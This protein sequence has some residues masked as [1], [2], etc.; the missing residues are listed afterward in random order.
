MISILIPAHK[1]KEILKFIDQI[2]YDIHQTKQIIVFNDR[3]G[4]GKGYALRE[5]LKE[6][7]FYEGTKIIFIDGDGDIKPEE[8][9]KIIVYLKQYDVVV[10]NK[11]L[12]K[13]FDRK[14]L[15]IL[16]RIYIRFMFKLSVDTQTG[17]KGFNYKPKWETDSWAFDI[18]I[19]DK[20]KKMGKSIIEIPVCATV[21][22][23]K[24]IKDIWKT[25]IDSIKIK[26]LL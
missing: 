23:T 5:A 14:L 2:E 12:P 4:K 9:N 15:T 19:L 6:V 24:S 18:E 1:E 17:I 11:G 10:G 7:D 20:A 21:S 8:I 26:F 3:Y 25:L 13:R 22:D 16:S